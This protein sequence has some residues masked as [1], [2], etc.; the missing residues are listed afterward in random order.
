MV[1]V[2]VIASLSPGWWRVVVGVGVGMLDG[3]SQQ[4][5]PDEH[6][7]PDAR[8]PNAEF[9]ISGIV[10]GKPTLVNPPPDQ[11]AT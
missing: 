4:D 7:P 9:W 5:W 8:L 6:I 2:R 10:D 3:G 11:T 1:R